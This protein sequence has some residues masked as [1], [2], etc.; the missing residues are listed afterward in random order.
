MLD[1][2]TGAA[3]A[4]G[5][6]YSSALSV[7]AALTGAAGILQATKS[8]RASDSFTT[9]SSELT[10][11]E[12]L[13]SFSRPCPREFWLT[14][15]AAKVLSPGW[16]WPA[17]FSADL[18][19]G[20]LGTICQENTRQ[21]PS[22]GDASFATCP[23]LKTDPLNLL[24]WILASFAYVAAAGVLPGLREVLSETGTLELL[25]WRHEMVFAPVGSRSLCKR[26]L[27]LHLHGWAIWF[28]VLAIGF[29]LGGTTSS[30]YQA[31]VR[32]QAA[33]VY[34]LFAIGKSDT[35]TFY[36]T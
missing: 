26:L 4:E 21:G 32:H 29:S 5:D 22:Q 17:I 3:G 15:T 16:A 10:G 24:S 23:F 30:L 34:A 9:D 11:T 1:R 25:G 28:S 27:Q 20:V 36:S 35:K 18:V 19:I 13:V 31:A 33:S 12:N 7:P 14:N 6:V 2:L 8:G